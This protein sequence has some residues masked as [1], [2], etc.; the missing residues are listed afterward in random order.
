M[1]ANFVITEKGP[2]VAK[3]IF[4]I[5]SN[6]NDILFDHRATSGAERASSLNRGALEEGNY[7]I[8]SMITIS[9][10]HPDHDAYTLNDFGW[11]AG[12]DPQFK[13]DRSALGLHPDGNVP[14]SRG[15]IVFPFADLDTSVRLKN[16]IM[17]GLE[18]QRK[19]PLLVM[20]L[21]APY[22]KA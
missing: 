6:N 20:S 21:N 10:D 2:K 22:T 1:K 19:I 18:S 12:I 15:C 16:L 13:T 8:D 9:K 4:T 3:G 5:T 7:M 14:G 17:A 11:F